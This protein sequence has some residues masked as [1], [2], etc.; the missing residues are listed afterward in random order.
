MEQF[1]TLERKFRRF[2]HTLDDAARA[3]R[4]LDRPV[5]PFAIGVGD[6]AGADVGAIYREARRNIGKRLRSSG[7]RS[8]C[9]GRHPKRVAQPRT[10][11]PEMLTVSLSHLHPMECRF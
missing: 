1:R 5:D 3:L 4:R 7:P 10:S 6:A 2:F 9:I 8:E 11:G